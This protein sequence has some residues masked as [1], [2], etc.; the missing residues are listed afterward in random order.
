M[1]TLKLKNHKIYLVL[2]NTKEEKE[3]EEELDSIKQYLGC[4]VNVGDNFTFGD[5]WQYIINEKEFINNVFY[6]EM[7]GFNLISYIKE[8]ESEGYEYEPKTGQEIGIHYLCV[9]WG[10]DH[11]IYDKKQKLEIFPDF[12]GVGFTDDGID[13]KI[14]E[15]HWGLEFSP[16]DELLPY[17]FK[18][19]NKITIYEPTNLDDKST[20]GGTSPQPV[21]EANMLLT[22]YEII[23]MIL[24]EITFCGE[25]SDRAKKMSQIDQAMADIKD[26]TI[27]TRPIDDLF[28]DKEKE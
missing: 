9:G 18:I 17:P 11:D 28:K 15:T 14:Y 4:E 13:D 6:Q 5:L 25:P 10:T 19:D 8:S 3:S 26:G 20:W 7:G 21:I 22:L 24:F 16:I 2:H 23:K 1:K 12:Y 27:K